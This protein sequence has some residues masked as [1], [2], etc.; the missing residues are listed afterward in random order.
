MKAIYLDS[1]SLFADLIK[2]KEG[3]RWS[4]VAI[5]DGDK[6]IE[7]D[8]WDGVRESSL[9]SMIRKYSHHAIIDIPV[10]D[11]ERAIRFARMQWGAPYDWTGVFGLG[12]DRNWQDPSCWYCSELF[13]G[14]VQA[15]GI[16]LP[17]GL[18]MIGVKY[19]LEIALANGAKYL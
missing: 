8:N 4:H 7:A 1:Q 11:E 2:W 15:G 13:A 9:A 10:P 3:G 5:I 12:I 14:A 19:S 17:H 6:A 18:R 16:K